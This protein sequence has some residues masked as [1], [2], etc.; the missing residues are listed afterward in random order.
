[1]RLTGIKLEMGVINYGESSPRS[2]CNQLSIATASA[3]EHKIQLEK[4]AI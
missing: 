2:Y 1:M 4:A 3:T